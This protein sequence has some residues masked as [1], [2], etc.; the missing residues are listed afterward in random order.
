[1]SYE[2][3]IGFRY[4]KAKRKQTFISLITFISIGGVAIGVTALIVVLAVMTGA[5]EDIKNKILGANS[6]IIITKYGGESFV[7]YKDVVS[8]A[9]N[10]EGV[11]AASPF[12]FRQVMLTSQERVTGAILRGVSTNIDQQGTDISQYMTEGGLEFLGEEHIRVSKEP[13]EFG[14]DTEYEMAGI[15]IGS[16]LARTLIAGVDDRITLVSPTGAITP[17]GAAPLTRDFY[18]VGIFSSGMYEYD[19]S[20]ALISLKQAQSFF[21]ME[22]EVSGVEIKVNDIYKAGDIADFME[23]KLGYP[24]KARDWRELNRNLFFALKLEKTVLGI[25]LTL[26]VCVAA[27]NIVSTLIMVVMEK[28]RDIA[29]LKAMGATRK[30]I[31]TIFLLEGTIIGF[32]GTAMGVIGGV[33][34]CNLLKKYQF[35]QIPQDVYNLDHLPVMMIPSD[36]IMV[37]LVAIVVT[38]LATLYPAWSA[39]RLDPAEA[40]RYE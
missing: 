29:V 4:L 18:V 16:E 36:V 37:S 17:G 40:L 10:K 28:S 24:F 2:W 34:L 35:I 26:I 13:D 9:R 21:K 19:S 39:S 31:M 32:A 23:A 25:I 12:I 7:D 6:H 8:M 15:V 3:F 22:N 5:Q 30:S 14:I 11:K 20:L 38:I 27:F 33:L 1:M